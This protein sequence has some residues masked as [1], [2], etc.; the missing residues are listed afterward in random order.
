M[1]QVK[2]HNISDYPALENCL[3]GAVRL[4]KN[5]DIDQ[6]KCCGYGFGFDRHGLSSHHSGG[7]GKN[8]IEKIF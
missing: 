6:Y 7:T 3:Y 4:T 1:R 2:K 5:A 8:V